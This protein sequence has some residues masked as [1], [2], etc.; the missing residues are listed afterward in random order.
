MPPELEPVI[1][2]SVEAPSLATAVLAPEPSLSLDAA[3][4]PTSPEP[5]PEAKEAS[6][7]P[8]EV[9]SLLDEFKAREPVKVEEPKPEEVKAPEPAKVDEVKPAD[10]A[11]P[12]EAKPEEAAPEPAPEAPIEYKF[13][14]PATIKDA[15][16]LKSYTDALQAAKAAPEFGQNLLNMHAEAMQ[17]YADHLASE[18]RRVFNETRKGWRTQVMADSQIGGSGHNTAMGAIARMRDMSISDAKPGS[19]QYDADKREFEDFLRMT[20]AGDHPAYLRQLHRFARYLDEA[21][22]P[23]PNP[24]PP[25]DIGKQPGRRGMGAI[26]DNPSSS[27]NR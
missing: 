14:L 16:L 3:P 4:A 5:T 25:K 21:A 19:P 2:P 27:H 6:P 7:H 17:Q 26:Y 23:P 8:A 11:R 13:E 22:L 1:T 20:G 24:K 15:P 9:P 12:E 18:Q 10:P